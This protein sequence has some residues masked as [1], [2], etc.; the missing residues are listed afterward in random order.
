MRKRETVFTAKTFSI[1]GSLAITIPKQI[2]NIME[3]KEGD[4]VIVSII[5]KDTQPKEDEKFTIYRLKQYSNSEHFKND[6][7]EILDNIKAKYGGIIVDFTHII[8]KT[9]DEINYTYRRKNKL[10]VDRF[11]ERVVPKIIRI[12]KGIEQPFTVS[13]LISFKPISKKDREGE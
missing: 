2:V 1:G 7:D 13:F 9:M 3:I 10:T 6:I 5:A 12:L 11:K 8:V 4:Y